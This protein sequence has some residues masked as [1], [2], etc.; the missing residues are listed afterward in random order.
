[1]AIADGEVTTPG[2]KGKDKLVAKR[3]DITPMPKVIDKVMIKKDVKKVL[4]LP[5]NVTMDKD[6]H[7]TNNESNEDSMVP[8]NQKHVDQKDFEEYHNL[9]FEL[10]INKSL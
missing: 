7:A 9:D 1:L 5:N 3:I 4:K 10:A 8:S 6:L 2:G